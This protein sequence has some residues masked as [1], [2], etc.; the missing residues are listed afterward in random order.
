M[1]VALILASFYHAH[2][3]TGTLFWATIVMATAGY[4]TL[5]PGNW[6]VDDFLLWVS[7]LDVA[8][9][10][11]FS[12]QSDVGTA[13]TGCASSMQ[14]CSCFT[15]FIAG[16]HSASPKKWISVLQSFTMRAMWN[17]RPD[18]RRGSRASET[19]CSEF[20]MRYG[21][22]KKRDRSIAAPFLDYR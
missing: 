5:T 21:G 15:N 2:E 11:A 16:Q 13:H 20:Q 7:F 10:A 8:S 1:C 22:N 18:G 19:G 3:R 4:V 14:Q 6:A 12:E 9:R 17:G